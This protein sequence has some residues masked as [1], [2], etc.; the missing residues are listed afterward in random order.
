MPTPETAPTPPPRIDI[1]SLDRDELRTLF[2]ELGE[3]AYRADQVHQ[4]LWQKHAQHFDDM[5]NLPKALRIK[6]HERFV[7]GRVQVATALQSNDGSSKFAFVLADGNRIEGVLIPT[8]DHSR[9]T[10]CISSQVGCSL[11]C[12]FCATGYLPLSRNLHAYEI[13]DQV[14]ILNTEAQE[15]YGR[16]LTNIVYMG[17]GEPLLNYR[18]VMRSIERITSP[19]GMGMSPRR[20]TL[21]TSGI[22]KMIRKLADDGFAC[23]FALSLHA[24]KDDVRSQIMSINDSNNLDNL[25][26][27]LQYFYDKTHTRVTFEYVVL[28]GVNDRPSDADALAAFARC[29]PSKINIIEYNSISEAGYRNSPYMDQFIRRLESHKLIVNVRRSR[30]KDIDGACG[31]LALK[32]LQG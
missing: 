22:A 7:L 16:G 5:S 14:A 30:G 13:V 3:P 10:A 31:Q 12:K 1:R 18:N 27:A 9:V 24:A 8:D 21:S 17:M 11:D 6:L 25:R 29:V 4:W 2:A 20:I 28:E 15:R 26:Q 23:E 32:Q 19:D